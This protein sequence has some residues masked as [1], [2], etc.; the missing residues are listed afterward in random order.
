[1]KN[2]YLS[3][4]SVLFL[5]SCGKKQVLPLG[6]PPRISS[7]EETTQSP[8]SGSSPKTETYTF[9]YDGQQR[10]IQVND[11]KFEYNGTNR[12][13][14]SRIHR[15]TDGY[16]QLRMEYIEKLRYEWDSQGRISRIVADSIYHRHTR[17]NDGP[18]YIGLSQG[19]VISRYTY[20][21]NSRMPK[22]IEYLTDFDR[23]AQ[24][25]KSGYISFEY[26]GNDVL[27]SAQFVPPSGPLP[28]DFPGG[29]TW[30][31]LHSH[32][33]SDTSPHYLYAAFQ[34]LG[35]HPYHF[36]KVVSQNH[37]S[38]VFQ[39]VQ[40]GNAAPVDLPDW[41]KAEKFTIESHSLGYPTLIKWK[42]SGEPASSSTIVIR[43]Q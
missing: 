2:S 16:E 21:E 17:N 1:M 4:L 36:H 24:S 29:A 20:T 30:F 27:R 9:L 39:E 42:G 13:V 31:T 14:S 3:I 8:I 43:Y 37:P 12:V 10:I 18:I 26:Q 34:Q 19:A 32:F 22:L 5:L 28:P 11:R 15:F 23:P 6:D 25:G 33:Q 38:K 7:V 40:R 41:N 35:F